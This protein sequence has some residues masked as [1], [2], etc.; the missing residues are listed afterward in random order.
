ML[1]E[2]IE[3]HL[4]EKKP[5][6]RSAPQ[7]DKSVQPATLPQYDYDF[8]EGGGGNNAS[9]ETTVK[10]HTSKPLLFSLCACPTLLFAEKK[11]FFLQTKGFWTSLSF[12]QRKSVGLKV[13]TFLV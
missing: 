6:E 11:H 5:F 12:T 4:V 1:L 10:K 3:T 13:C 9:S 7:Q 2:E 8:G